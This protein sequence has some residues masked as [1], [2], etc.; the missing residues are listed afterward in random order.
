MLDPITLDAAIARSAVSFNRLDISVVPAAVCAA[1]TFAPDPIDPTAPA[2]S[3]TAA[4]DCRAL[5]I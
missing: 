5:R 4:A 1:A 2:T 3:R